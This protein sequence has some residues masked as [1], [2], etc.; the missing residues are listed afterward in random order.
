MKTASR[1][2]SALVFLFLYAPIIVLVLFSFNS[3]SSTSVF[4]GFSLQWYKSLFQD[5][6]TLRALYNTLI[7]AVC[8]SVAATVI[9]TAAAVGIDKFKKG[10]ARSSVM[11]VTNI[12]MMN[13]EIVTGISMMLLFVFVGR[14]VNND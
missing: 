6:A 9:G 13:P 12:P 11:A 7:L 1:I 14:L 4:A 2:Y 8:S 10:V 3:S 5:E